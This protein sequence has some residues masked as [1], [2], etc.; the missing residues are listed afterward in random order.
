MPI[1]PTAPDYVG[2]VRGII[3]DLRENY[4]QKQ[5]LFLEEKDQNEKLGLNYAQLDLQR[6]QLNLQA[7][8]AAVQA[9]IDRSKIA[10]AAQQT[11][12]QAAIEQAR[13][14]SEAAKINSQ[15]Y[16]KSVKEDLDERK[17]QFD[18]WKENKKLEDEQRLRDQ[19]TSAARLEHEGFVALNSDDPTKLIEWT[20]KMAGSL[21]AQKQ[22]NDVFQNALSLVNAK[23]TMEQQT[24]N[25]RT[26]PKA[27]EIVQGLNMLD[28]SSMMP[29]QFADYLKKATDDF[30]NLGNTDPKMNDVFMSVSQEVAKRQSDFRQKEYGQAM[31]SYL[32]T[33]AIGELNPEDQSQWDQ[34]QK[35]YPE[36]LRGSSTDYSDKIRR[37]M[38]QSNKRNSIAKLRALDKQNLNIAENLITQNPDLAAQ[39]T[40]PQTK[41]VYRVF[42]YPSPDLTPNVGSDSAIDPETGLLTKNITEANTK[43]VSEVTSP[44]FLL[45]QVPFVRGLTS[46]LTPS[47]KTSGATASIPFKTESLSKFEDVPEPGTVNIVTTPVAKETKIS[48]ST[49]S[50]IVEAYRKNPEAIVYGRPAREI[51]ANLRAKGYAIPDSIFAPTETR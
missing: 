21:M 1:T 43:W 47:P 22:R 3:G 27:L 40:D 34:L 38:F 26:Q 41:E 37:L 4:L 44:S 2:Q 32:R 46:G 10:L 14:G 42:P 48:D 39:K 33:A 25:L 20:N 7:N 13:Y 23:K 35:D 16:T 50:T 15:S 9:S 30:K 24:S 49:I 17:F 51:L 36:S 18:L 19:E 6:D 11:T 28:V 29:N 8:N 12:A 31:D 45:G 5:K